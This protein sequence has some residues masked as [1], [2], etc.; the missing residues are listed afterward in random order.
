TDM[1]A[2]KR[3]AEAEGLDYLDL[4][5]GNELYESHTTL[6]ASDSLQESVLEMASAP[7]S[8]TEQVVKLYKRITSSREDGVIQADISLEFG[9]D[10]RSMFHYLKGL[11]E[12]NL[13][14]K[15]RDS[16]PAYISYLARS[17]KVASIVSADNLRI[18]KS[19]IDDLM[20]ENFETRLS[21]DESIAKLFLLLETAKNKTL[22]IEDL[23]EALQMDPKQ[24]SKRKRFYQDLNP[25]INDGYVSLVRVPN[26][27]LGKSGK[28]SAVCLQLLK[29]FS[30]AV[31]EQPI[32]A[33]EEEVVPLKVDVGIET[34]IYDI[35]KSSG[36]DGIFT[37][38]IQRLV[39]TIGVKPLGKWLSLLQGLDPH[40]TKTKTKTKRGKQFIKQ[41]VCNIGRVKKAQF[42]TMDAFQGKEVANSF[43]VDRRLS[44]IV[45]SLEK[46]H[47]LEY[48]YNSLLDILK[49]DAKEF[50]P[51]YAEYL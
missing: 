5:V 10:P 39:P 44:L 8:W 17:T 42:H 28:G 51:D 24:K 13:I 16:S 12:S 45:R 50:D 30:A 3:A 29:A 6:L 26:A 34:Q 32:D 27:N 33:V 40:K 47:I 19:E 22:T 23:M 1:A 2:L 14:T 48:G 7:I 25:Y 20:F 15:F 37:Q 31:E 46:R 4:G 43:T 49:D 41:T 36:V 9:L 11:L 35:I 38:D 21:K 18:E